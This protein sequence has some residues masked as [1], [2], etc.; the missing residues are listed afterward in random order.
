MNLSNLWQP[1][2][3]ISDKELAHGLRMM[4]WEG[5]VSMAMFSVTTSGLLAAFAL[6]LGA[7][8]FQIGILAALPFVMNLFQLPAIFLVERIRLR[9]LITIAS[10]LPAQ[11]IWLPI[12]AIPVFVGAPSALAVSLLL[13]LMALR[14]LLSAVTNT[15]WNG[16]IRDLVPQDIL[17]KFFSQ[18]LA[19]ATAAAMVFGLGG[20]FFVD[21]W[22][23]RA[24]PDTEIFGYT[25]VLLA[26]A[27][28]LGLASP[29]FMTRMPE[30]RMSA[31]TGE[32][33]SLRKALRQPIADR[34]YRQ[35]LN[36][37]L[38]WGFAAN[39]AI[40]FF[41]IYMLQRLG[42]SLTSVIALN[43][44]AQLT[45]IMFLG[46]WG[47][48]SDR[49]GIKVVLSLTVSLYLL[50][51]L[52]WAFTTMPDR[53]FLTVPLVIGLQVFAGIAAAGVNLTVGT[54]GLK[55]APKGQA[56]P[57]LAAASLASNIGAGLGPLVG[58]LLADFMSVRE[59][60]ISF[61]WLSPDNSVSL[62]VIHMTGFDFLFVISF[63]I[64]LITLN[65]LSTIREEGE[66]DR[67]VVL[68][69][70]LAPTRDM[71]KAI[72]SFPGSRFVTGFP[73]AYLSRIPGLDVAIGVTGYQVASSVK[74]AV[75]STQKAVHSTAEIADHV[76]HAAS[77]FIHRAV[78]LT[79]WSADLAHHAVK[80]VVDAIGDVPHAAGTV[81]G[82][83]ALGIIR[84]LRF[85]KTTPEE[86]IKGAAYGVV[87]GANEMGI[88]PA[89][90]M[91]DVVAA[92]RIAAKELH[93]PGD[94]AASIATHSAQEALDAIE[95]GKRPGA[96]KSP[97]APYSP[98]E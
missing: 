21:Y 5:T 97:T 27:V 47:R 24:G 44:L 67:S 60:T 20:A 32:S 43:S 81:A 86:S 8:N 1:K 93:L 65:M 45:N 85:S 14:G 96:P 16:W 63:I 4:T 98:A 10:W 87:L 88:D 18:R 11:L 58:G 22:Q 33:L 52:G 94:V 90:I 70:L 7:N 64:G 80:G 37:L 19:R 89:T 95:Q 13:G 9:K 23:G 83:T 50:V 30:P 72:G 25:Y 29:L 79:Q 40:P 15:A 31:P 28:V 39:L 68:G 3:A 49:F 76:Q 69:E 56:T 54:I 51:I 71:T 34:N 59:L 77:G 46:V 91:D 73:Y 26:G 6:A 78:D 48:F 35:L 74:A 53:Y 62:P 92:A 41:T 66:V 84:A 57:Y 42:F 12:A 61:E 38:F 36:F 2:Q 82:G 17:G 75:T 55:L